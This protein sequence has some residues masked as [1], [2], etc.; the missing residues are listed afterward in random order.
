LSASS[1]F[2]L[3]RER[4][5]APLFWVQFLGAANDNIFKFAFTLLAT[6]SASRWGGVEP[7]IAG[8]LIAGLFIAPFMLFSAT[9]GQL[10]DKLE[11]SSFIRR[12]KDAEIGVMLVGGAGL[13]L[14]A[15]VLVYLAVFLLGLQT[16]VFGPVKYSYL[17]QHL[18]AH[19]VTGGNGMVEMGT[20]VAILLG[21][22]GGGLLISQFGDSGAVITA[23]VCVLCAILGRIAAQFV[24]HSP[25]ADPALTINWNPFTE[26]WRNLRI[27]H[28]N[29]AVFNSIVGISW[30]WFFGSVFL[31]SFTPFAR[32][33]LGGTE[34]VVTFLLA[35]FSIG[36]GAGSLACE[37]L[38]GRRVEI[39]LVP[40]GSIGMTVFAIDLYLA[41]TAFRA[42]HDGGL[43]QFF[44]SSGSWRIVTDLALLAFFA[45]LYSVPLYA[46]IQTRSDRSRV[47]RIVAANN[48]LNA[49]F[50][51]V[52]SLMAAALL[53][54]GLTI[55]QLFLVTGLM[56]AAVAIYI[57]RLV[58]EFLLRFLAWLLT[59]T[60]YR[61]RSIGAE[62]IP[63]DG[64]AV[65]ACNH[66][67]FVDAVVIMGESPRP[68]RFV[69]DHRIFK[70]PLINW[71]FRT[72]RAIA[73]A[74][75][76][77]DPRMLD[78]ANQRI[79]AALA[80]GDLVCIFPEGKITYDGE[81]SPFKQGVQK[82][83]ERTP[84]P[85]IP[86]ALRGLWGSFF[87]RYGGAAFTRPV[88]ARLQRGFR[89]KLE[90]V[91]GQP[92]PPHEVTPDMLMARVAALH[93]GER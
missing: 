38:S 23:A 9:S 78:G 76:R 62:R 88:E 35:A 70:I 5:F 25:A 48:I 39:G 89:S 6:Y 36:I 31:T 26:T 84:V 28:G 58:P 65:L 68:I 91:V 34:V 19:E 49:V 27:A 29:A 75:A 37:R 18:D 64:P 8:F 17:P 93:A 41:S 13:V 30:L 73:I 85:V 59:H 63:L 4:R 45:G 77:E 66:V 12:V 21:T 92:V 20:F 44:S 52:A 10:A 81:L 82:I 47:A 61:I 54:S 53:E 51:V 40:L 50:M 15:P 1:Q 60:I 22:I 72:A 33:N 24:P 79:D 86:M 42:M 11:K 16:T 14:H 43:Q 7:R 32:E 87:S 67:S 74:P 80:D 3:L 55:P 83:V 57:Y 2:T 56:N 46:L 71:F 69:M 90:L